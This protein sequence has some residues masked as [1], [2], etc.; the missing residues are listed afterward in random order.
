VLE[1]DAFVER[2]G[3]DLSLA[4]GGDSSALALLPLAHRL[5]MPR[6]YAACLDRLSGHWGLAAEALADRET[7]AALPPAVA[8]DLLW[9]A[10]KA[11]VAGVRLSPHS[12]SM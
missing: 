11:A 2:H 3:R 5:D 9:A 1:A 6:A 8:K 7:V 4:G 12:G 10:A